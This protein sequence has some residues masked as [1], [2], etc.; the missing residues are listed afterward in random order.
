MSK[1]FRDLTCSSLVLKIYLH[2]HFFFITKILTDFHKTV[3]TGM[4]PRLHTCRKTLQSLRF[5]TFIY[6]K[7]KEEL[8]VGLS[9]APYYFNHY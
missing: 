2:I 3:E 7:I 9:V 6:G 5:H 4:D 8:Q 1:Y